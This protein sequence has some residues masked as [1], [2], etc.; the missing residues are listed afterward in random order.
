M[1]SASF[2]SMYLTLDL[3]VSRTYGTDGNIYKYKGREVL[4]KILPKIAEHHSR[5]EITAIIKNRFS[6]DYI[7]KESKDEISIDD[8][9]LIFEDEI[10]VKVQAN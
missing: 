1:I 9:T 2:Y 6:T 4:Q 8:V 5:A 7:I 3:G 10:L